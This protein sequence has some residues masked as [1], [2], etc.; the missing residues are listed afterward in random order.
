MLPNFIIGL[1][2]TRVGLVAGNYLTASMRNAIGLRQAEIALT[3]GEL[4]DT[5]QALKMG[6]I[7]EIALNKK[8]GIK[9]AEIFLEKFKNVSPTA[10]ALTKKAL[11]NETIQVRTNKGGKT[12]RYKTR[13]SIIFQLV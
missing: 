7:D 10:R 4:F 12:S 5:H 11:R 8:E 2:E 1:N 6:L 13:H 9:K 3:T